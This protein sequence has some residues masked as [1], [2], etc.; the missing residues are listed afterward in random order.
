MLCRIPVILGASRPSMAFDGIVSA[1]SAPSFQ[2][3]VVGVGQY[4]QPVSSVR[5]PDL[6]SSYKLPLRIEP[7]GGKVSENPVE[8][9]PK[10]P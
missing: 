9:Q 7:E 1:G 4:E 5:R 8:S 10:V 6:A 2:S 3:R